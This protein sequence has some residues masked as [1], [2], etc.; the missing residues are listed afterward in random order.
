MASGVARPEPDWNHLLQFLKLFFAYNMFATFVFYM[1]A[2]LY[3]DKE[4]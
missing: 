2:G 1:L 4:M 3:T